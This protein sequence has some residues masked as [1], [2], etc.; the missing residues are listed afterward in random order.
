MPKVS[1]S[2]FLTFL[3]CLELND[4]SASG[5]TQSADDPNADLD[6]EETD[7]LLQKDP[8][9]LVEENCRNQQKKGANN[10]KKEGECLMFN[11]FK[12]TTPPHSLH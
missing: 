12:F 3:P 6:E 1:G 2:Y 10:N 9:E 5:Q 7:K 11:L 8:N 4:P